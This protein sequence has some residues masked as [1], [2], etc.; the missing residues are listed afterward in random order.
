MEQGYILKFFSGDVDIN[1]KC[2]KQWIGVDNTL[3][4]KGNNRNTAMC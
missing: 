1:L 4:Y 2:D 3:A